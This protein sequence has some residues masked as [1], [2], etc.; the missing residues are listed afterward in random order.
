MP[1]HRHQEFLKFLKAIDRATPKHLDIHGIA[2]TYATPKKQGVKDGNIRA[3]T[4]TLFRHR[5][6]G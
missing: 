3:S 4:S 1:R 2:H 6:R 5:H